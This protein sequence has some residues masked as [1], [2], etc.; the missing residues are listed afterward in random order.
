[1]QVLEDIVLCATSIPMSVQSSTC[2]KR[3]T[4]SFRPK[5]IECIDQ[6][7]FSKLV[8][9]SHLQF[10]FFQ[11]MRSSCGRGKLEEQ[12]KPEM[13]FS[14]VLLFSLTPSSRQWYSAL[15]AFSSLLLPSCPWY[16]R[17]CTKNRLQYHKGGGKKFTTALRAVSLGCWNGLR[18]RCNIADV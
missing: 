9:V 2:L 14:Q 1:M 8:H 13:C 17:R 4:F 5:F 12:V 18:I 6:L 3:F 15:R 7:C 10:L 16:D 11:H